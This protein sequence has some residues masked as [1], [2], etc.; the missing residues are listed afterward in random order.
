MS[1]LIETQENNVLAVYSKD[2]LAV[3]SKD[4]GLNPYIEEIKTMVG[5][6]E[7]DMSTGAKRDKTKSFAAKIAKLKV[8]IDNMGKDLTSEWKAKSKAVDANRKS[9]R[10]EMDALRDEARKPLTDWE[11]EESRKKAEEAAKVEAEKVAAEILAAHEIALFMNA[12]FDRNKQMEIER[13]AAEQEELKRK[14]EDRIKALELAA[15]E[16]AKQ[17]AELKAKQEI[18]RREREKQEAIRREVEAKA[19]AE[20][21]EKLRIES[22]E[23]ERKAVIQR[24][25]ERIAEEKQAVENARIAAEKARQDEIDRQ[26]SELKQQ[27]EEDAK[28]E[29]DKKHVSGIRK[30]AKENL[31]YACGLTEEQAKKVVLAI[32]SNKILNV[33]IKY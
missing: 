19:K 2:V 3:Y 4:G 31:M 12:D 25:Q 6:F 27:Q 23:R 8:R 5:N 11:A 16:K 24:E 32:N 17:D 13:I 18:E 9:F 26:Q 33:S 14:E 20:A 22:E 15:A 1:E 21:Q 10:D 29:A 7:H 30:Q 28:R